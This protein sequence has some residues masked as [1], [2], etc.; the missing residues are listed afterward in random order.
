MT[1]ALQVAVR[2][3]RRQM[4]DSDW[5]VLITSIRERKL[6]PVIGPD[7]IRVPFLDQSVTY[8]QY[9]AKRLAD[10]PDYRLSDEDLLPL[11]VTL[12]Q[13]SLN[14]IVSACVRKH[15]SHWPFELHAH[16]WQIVSESQFPIPRALTQLAKIAPLNL[17]VNATFDPLLASAL[18]SQGSLEEVIYR[19]SDTDPADLPKDVKKDPRRFLYYL[20]GKAERG[21]EDFAICEVELLRSLVKLHDAK[22]RPKRL[23]DALR[24]KH[25]L[26]LG[27]NF[28]DWLARFFLWLARD[29][30][31]AGSKQEELR[32]YLDDPKVD[33]DRSLVVFLQHFSNS[34][35]VVGEEPEEFVSELYRRWCED[36]GSAP[37]EISAPETPKEMPKGA[38]FLSYSRSD[39]AA[40]N[41]LFA[42]LRRDGIPAWYDAGLTGGDVWEEKI[43]RNIDS[44]GVF[45][46][47]V[48]MQ[49]LSRAKSEFRAEWLQ[50]VNLDKRNFGTGE[51][52]IVPVLVDD[53]D[54]VLRAPQD[55]DLPKEFA[56]A[57]MFHCPR[58]EPSR[59]LVDSLRERLESGRRARGV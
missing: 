43:R 42:G 24:E 48:S 15:S 54:A 28:S 52:I 29:R 49:A 17:F 18:R 6:I 35:V 23:F 32:E 3:T 53:E 57:Q 9:V 27:V 13:A 41:T 19:R 39:K 12:A 59:G 36:T 2:S 40:A 45:V 5:W 8:E 14:D 21:R 46:P 30:G 31:N 16:V 50:A 7:L 33:Q 25:L 26:L 34:T 20:F 1:D 10:H 56:S 58:G 38:V 37:R 11:G 47:L 22:Y 4:Q 44:C 51:T 55:F